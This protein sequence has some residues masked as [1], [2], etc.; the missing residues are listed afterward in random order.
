MEVP[1]MVTDVGDMGVLVRLYAAGLVCRPDV[2][3][4][5]ETLLRFVS[6]SESTSNN[7]LRELLDIRA[8]A[9]H[10]LSDITS[11]SRTVDRDRLRSRATP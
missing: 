11:T 8:S 7:R 10:F 1:V 3:D 4:M 6:S 5:A 2:D 9:E